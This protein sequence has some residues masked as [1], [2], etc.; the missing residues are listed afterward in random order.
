[1]LIHFDILEKLHHCACLSVF[2]LGNPRRSAAMLLLDNVQEK[3][4]WIPEI[5]FQHVLTASNEKKKSARH[6]AETPDDYDEEPDED[7]DRRI[8]NGPAKHKKVARDDEDEN[9]AATAS[10]TTYVHT[11]TNT[12]CTL[13]SI[14]Y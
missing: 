3:N 7:G 10:S 13:L 11:P 12:L 9:T 8:S 6:S 1:M 5:H 14:V 4:V 2:E